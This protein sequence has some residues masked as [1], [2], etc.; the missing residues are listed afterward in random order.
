MHTGVPHGVNENL[1]IPSI[2]SFKFLLAKKFYH[3]AVR[4]SHKLSH[5]AQRDLVK[6]RRQCFDLGIL[7]RHE[8]NR[9]ARVASAHGARYVARSW[10]K[11]TQL[12]CHFNMSCAKTNFGFA[13]GM[14]FNPPPPPM[15]HP[16]PLLH[17]TPPC[18]SSLLG[19]VKSWHRQPARPELVIWGLRF[20]SADQKVTSRLFLL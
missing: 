8:D 7:I 4:V 13:P 11:R 16:Q 6:E 1:T 20:C 2:R 18:Q 12:A 9:V 14:R 17:S 15:P 19:L 5:T 10:Q 3:V